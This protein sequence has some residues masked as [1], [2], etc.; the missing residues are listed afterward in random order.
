MDP[1]DDMEGRCMKQI[2]VVFL[3]AA[4]LSIGCGG[5]FDRAVDPE[6]ERVV[7]D[8]HAAFDAKDMPR[9]TKLCTEDM[10]WYTLNGKSMPRDLLAGFFRSMF[11]AW[12]GVTT[13]LKDLS[14]VRSGPLAV[15]RYKS[16]LHIQVQSRE[17]VLHSLQTTVLI[18]ERGQWL[19]WQHHMSIE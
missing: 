3:T 6:V 12:G 17:S 19:V 1:T 7:K 13:R 5:G 18:R 4:V 15:V 10:Q 16:E 14:M 2:M 9:L 8:F 11:D